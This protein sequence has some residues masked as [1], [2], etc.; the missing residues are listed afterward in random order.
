M[1]KFL[2]AHLTLYVFHELYICHYDVVMMFLNEVFDKS[3][4]IIYSIEFEEKNYILKLLKVLYDLK[5]SSHVWY[6]HLCEHLEIIEL[7]I[8]SYDLSVFINKDLL[9]NLIVTVY[10]N[11]LLICSEFM[12][13][14]NNI[15][16]HLQTEFEMTDLDKVMNY[17]NMKINVAA[18]K[19]IV[20]QYDYIWTVLKWFDMNECK[21]A[22]VLMQLNMKLMIYKKSLNTE[23]QTWY[24][25][26]VES[27]MWSVTQ[28]RSDIVYA[29]RVVSWYV[30]NSSKQHKQAVKQIF[31]YLKDTVNHE[32]IYTKHSRNLIN[33]NDSNYA[34]DVN[35][36]WSITEYVFLLVK[37]LI[38]YKLSLMKIITLLTAETEYM[39]LCLTA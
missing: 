10:V 7:I 1:N 31:C 39:I 28:S 22:S 24:R 35:T 30:S 29:V 25:S 21:P 14:I 8:N 18:D 5:Q 9:M 15:L 37:N 38:V 4:Y 2:K 34:D 17:L 13:L 16:K 26:A 23:H 19:I 36:C 12:K 3:L 20:H 11:D 32:L 6:A 27:L 33:Y